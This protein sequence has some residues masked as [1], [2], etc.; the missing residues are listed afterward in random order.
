MRVDVWQAS[1]RR[2]ALTAVALALAALTACASAPRS[3]APPTSVTL[4]RPSTGSSPD[5]PPVGALLPGGAV[6]GER[7]RCMDRELARRGLNEFGDPTGTTYPEGSPLYDVITKS[8]TDR[9]RFVTRRHPDIGAAC[10][11]APLQPER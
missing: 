11:S 8:S 7:D 6:R 4:P 2:A 5:Q 10:S 1:G 9:F 3:D